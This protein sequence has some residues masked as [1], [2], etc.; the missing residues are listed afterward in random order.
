M[1]PA[2]NQDIFLIARLD[3][4]TST[5]SQAFSYSLKTCTFWRGNHQLTE[6]VFAFQ[7]TKLFLCSSD[8][9]ESVAFARAQGP[10]SVKKLGESC[11]GYHLSFHFQFLIYDRDILVNYIFK[12]AL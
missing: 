11:E 10:T 5:K 9:A 4:H 7:E 12:I 8:S 6:R 2:N 3:T 1:S